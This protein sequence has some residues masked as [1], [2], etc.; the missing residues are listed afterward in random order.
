MEIVHGTAGAFEIIRNATSEAPTPTERE[1][2][3]YLLRGAASGRVPKDEAASTLT[4]AAC[5]WANFKLW[6]QVIDLS[7]AVEKVGVV[8]LDELLEAFVCFGIARVQPMYVLKQTYQLFFMFADISFL[9][10]IE[11]ILAGKPD[12][13]VRLGFL[14]DLHRRV[15][16]QGEHLITPWIIQQRT[17]VT[18]TL[19]EPKKGE[20]AFLLSLADE[21]GGLPFLEE[22]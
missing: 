9:Q 6:R 18:K 5:R 11:D 17:K 12:N 2:V 10:S 13:T 15:E 22:T 16:G 8:S 4:K 14:H 19:K 7:G 1:A 21:C 20:E 3:T